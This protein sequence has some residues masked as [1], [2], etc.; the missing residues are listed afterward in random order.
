[1][2]SG[3]N[4]NLTVRHRLLDPKAASFVHYVDLTLSSVRDDGFE[5]VLSGK[6]CQRRPASARSTAAAVTGWLN[7]GARS[8]ATRREKGSGEA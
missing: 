1:M 2:P 7:R 5:I 3:F 8:G 6:R 4:L